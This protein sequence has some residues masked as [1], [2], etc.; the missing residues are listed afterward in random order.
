MDNIF[1]NSKELLVLISKWKKHL[2]IVGLISLVGSILFSSPLFIKPKFKSFA[3]ACS[4]F[5]KSTH[6]LRFPT[7][8]LE[9]ARAA[10]VK[11]AVRLNIIKV[12]LLIGGAR[13]HI[14]F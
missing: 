4:V 9:A 10:E 11:I 14:F 12:L 6:D 7:L 5:K 8:Q 2:I 13:F 1:F 3:L